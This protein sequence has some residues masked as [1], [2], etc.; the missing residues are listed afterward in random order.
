ME[1][2]QARSVVDVHFA[3]YALVM[4]IQLSF[5]HRNTWM[6]LRNKDVS[7]TFRFRYYVFVFPFYALIL[8]LIITSAPGFTTKLISLFTFSGLSFPSSNLIS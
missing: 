5:P 2:L 6:S 8:S 3:L 7:S 4:Q 1:D